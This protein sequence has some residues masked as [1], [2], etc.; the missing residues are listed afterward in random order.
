[1]AAAASSSS[2][3]TPGCCSTSR[4]EREE[5]QLS[6]PETWWREGVVY[7]IYPR[8]FLDSDGDGVGD[9]AGITDRVGYLSWLGVDAIWISS[10][11]RSPMADFGSDI[12]HHFTIDTP[13]GTMAA[14]AKLVPARQDI[15]ERTHG[16][17]HREYNG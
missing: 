10:V 17:K 16:R 14:M 7:Q 15:R 9:L 2:A 11:Y 13:F 12:S 4:S 3:T 5:Q 8:S 1:M 6:D